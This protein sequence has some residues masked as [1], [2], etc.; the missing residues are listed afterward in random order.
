MHFI[1]TAMLQLFK[2]L[3]EL[4]IWGAQH[5]DGPAIRS[6]NRGDSHKSAN[7][8]SVGV[9]RAN[10]LKSAIRN[11]RVSQS[12]IRKRSSVREPC[13]DSPESG[14]SR[15]SANRFARSGPGLRCSFLL[16][17]FCSFSSG[18]GCF[19]GKSPGERS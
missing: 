7:F 6:A 4:H 11:F 14:D 10:R 9:I 17:F 5:L 12:A 19:E 3:P 16:V 13:N 18:T 8:H 2:S 1:W 15:E